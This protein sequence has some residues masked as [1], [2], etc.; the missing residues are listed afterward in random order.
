M[1]E[2]PVVC[3][4]PSHPTSGSPF[5]TIPWFVLR[6]RRIK[7]NGDT[8]IFAVLWASVQGKWL[9]RRTSSEASQQ[10]ISCSLTNQEIS[11]R[12][13]VGSCDES[14]RYHLERLEKQ[15]FIQRHGHHRSRVIEIL[16]LPEPNDDLLGLT[17]EEDILESDLSLTQKILAQTLRSFPTMKK[18]K[19]LTRLAISEWTYF[20]N[21]RKLEY[22]KQFKAA[23]KPPKESKSNPQKNLSEP[24]EKSK[25]IIKVE[26]GIEKTGR[27]LVPSEQGAIAPTPF[28]NSSFQEA[29]N[30]MQTSLQGNGKARRMRS[31]L[32]DTP[33]AVRKQIEINN[34]KIPDD[35]MVEL[36]EEVYQHPHI[37][38]NKTKS[39]IL[40]TAD[41]VQAL[42]RPGG[43]TNLI[44]KE[45]ISLIADYM[46][47]NYKFD[48]QAILQV[49][50]HQF[51]DEERVELYERL[52]NN[53][54]LQYGGPGG[55]IDLRDAAAHRS[56]NFRGFSAVVL[57][58]LRP[59]QL[60]KLAP[61]T[62]KVPQELESPIR[63]CRDLI[64]DFNPS[65]S[66]P[67]L[68][69]L[70]AHHQENVVPLLEHLGNPDRAFATWFRGLL[71]HAEAG[72]K[73][74]FHLGWVRVGG[75][76]FL[77]WDR[78]YREEEHFNHRA[79]G[80]GQAMTEAW[81]EEEKKKKE[82]AFIDE[83]QY[84]VR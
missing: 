25:P 24:P 32:N 68:K 34:R 28:Q 27:D 82:E 84:G 3:S 65:L 60:K 71:K 31:S 67:I 2:D 39:A 33:S 7:S 38:P 35:V 46:S 75:Q 72:D 59:P 10:K 29:D 69:E 74:G 14:I 77:E 15:G 81:R 44:S 48:R 18:D 57:V 47:K 17:L 45:E 9:E 26:R 37:T 53:M 49:L 21:F 20:S 63:I 42:R 61:P 70:Y 23:K 6:D 79:R 62:P 73:P 1:P 52:S 76:A 36:T 13:G 64:R 5:R 56:R 16:L 22:L 40:K 4:R 8:I 50:G 78:Y 43:L 11:T 55:K 30:K 83:Y 12:S 19:I 54:S 58:W 66:L 41:T 51:S 80:S